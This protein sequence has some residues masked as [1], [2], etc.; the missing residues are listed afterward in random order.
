MKKEEAK[1]KRITS[2]SFEG[3]SFLLFVSV[4]FSNERNESVSGEDNGSNYFD[5]EQTF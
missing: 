1:K 3:G 5:G 2:S 4:C